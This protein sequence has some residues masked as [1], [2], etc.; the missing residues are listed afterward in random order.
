MPLSR[1]IIGRRFRVILLGQEIDL[2][3]AILETSELEIQ[4]GSSVDLSSATLE[5]GN[6]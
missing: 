6:P 1:L 5:T 4:T 2:S 3:S